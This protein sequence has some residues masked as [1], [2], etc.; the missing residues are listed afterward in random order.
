M[1]QMKSNTGQYFEKEPLSEHAPTSFTC[2]FEGI[3]FDFNGDSGIF[4]MKR[5]DHGSSIMINAYIKERRAGR[6]KGISLLDMGCGYGLVGVVLK[7]VFPELDVTMIDINRRAVEYAKKNSERNSVR[8][9]RVLQA[10]GTESF[11]AKYDTVLLNPPVRAGK[12]VVFSMYDRI[13][14]NLNNGGKSYI[15]IQTKQ[16]AASSADKLNSLFGNCE[17]LTIKSGYRVFKCVKLKEEV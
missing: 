1:T 4:S 16:G 10:D 17:T 9:V 14:E 13:Y 2:R 15:V 6:D 11:D 5:A 12:N 7:R 3:G 8:F